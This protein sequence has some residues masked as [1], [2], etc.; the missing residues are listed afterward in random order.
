MKKRICLFMLSLVMMFTALP[1]NV[2]AKQ[3]DH[4]SKVP[5]ENIQIVA[6]NDNKLLINNNGKKTFITIKENARTRKA[7]ITNDNGK[8]LNYFEFD[9]KNNTIYSSI[10]HKTRKVST[11][12]ITTYGRKSYYT[13]KYISYRE[14]RKHL[15]TTADIVAIATIIALIAGAGGV[16]TIIGIIGS[17]VWVI[18]KG[19]RSNS[20]KH[21]VKVRIYVKK[22]CRRRMGRNLCHST[23]SISSISTY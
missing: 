7:I 4:H 19:I 1:L 13:N 8:V 22:H 14:I 21:G 18:Q 12:E 10:T 15:S 23:R 9:K 3:E 6:L 17:F 11:E 16:G 2:F 20:S 5:G